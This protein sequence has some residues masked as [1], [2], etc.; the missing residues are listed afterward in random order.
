MVGGDTQI[1]KALSGGHN[2]IFGIVDCIIMGEIGKVLLYFGTDNSNGVI[3][4]EMQT[5]AYQG[6]NVWWDVVVRMIEE[7]ARWI[8]VVASR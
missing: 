5:L 6:G 4:F 8:C 2:W 3:G 7:V 1:V